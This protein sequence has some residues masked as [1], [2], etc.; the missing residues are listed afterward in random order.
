MLEPIIDYLWK[1][2]VKKEFQLET[3]EEFSRDPSEFKKKYSYRLIHYSQLVV[4]FSPEIIGKIL[5]KLDINPSGKRI[6]VFG[7]YTGQFAE[8]LRNV[9]FSVIFTDP[10]KDYVEGAK[11][12]G[13][14]SYRYSIEELPAEIIRRSDLLATFECYMP[15]T[16]P[17]KKVY[18]TLRLLSAPYGFIFAESKRTREE[19]KKEGGVA[20]FKSQFKPFEDNYSIER[21]FREHKGLRFYHFIGGEDAH[22]RIM[23]DCKIINLIYDNSSTGQTERKIDFAFVDKISEVG[24]LSKNQVIQ[25]LQRIMVVYHELIPKSLQTIFSSNDFYIFPKRF[26][27]EL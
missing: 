8:A 2:Q 20:Q 4:D 5:N 9:D 3:V 6:T 13:F 21:R 16:S 19:L 7:G 11:K 17:E 12:K 10:I 14:E 22:N 24:K 27:F 26:T 15:F 23:L 1:G 25:S 18:T